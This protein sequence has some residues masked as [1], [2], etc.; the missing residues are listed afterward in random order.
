MV[1]FQEFVE[2]ARKV[3]GNNC[4]YFEDEFVKMSVNTKM[5]CNIHKLYFWQRPDSH[6]N[7]KGT[8]GCPECVKIKA[9]S[10][11]QRKLQKNKETFFKE[12][13]IIH[14]DKYEY[15]E[16]NY[17]D[18]AT[19]MQIW[20]KKCQ[21]FF[22]QSPEC[23]LRGQGCPSCGSTRSNQLRFDLAKKNFFAK[24]FTMHEKDYIF[25]KFEYKG[26]NIDGKL[27]CV[28]CN[29]YIWMSPSSLLSGQNCY[30]CSL[31]RVAKEKRNR[32]GKVFKPKYYQKYPNGYDL[33]QFIYLGSD[34]KGI[35]ICEKHGEFLIT[36]SDLLRGYNCPDCSKSK[37]EIQLKI[38][39]HSLGIKF[40]EQAPLNRTKGYNYR[41]DFYLPD[42]DLYIEYQ[43][44]QHYEPV[45]FFGGWK[46]F[47]S[48]YMKDQYKRDW[49]ERNKHNLLEI[50]YTNFD[51]MKSII[52]RKLKA[53]DKKKEKI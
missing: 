53:I 48:Q 7:G 50:K 1:T 13:P 15:F 10:G 44:I 36:P 38:I 47:F 9:Q 14:Q 43:G 28:S 20:C 31:K 12:A 16:E 2:R 8:I 42:Y 41:F 17:K 6:A 5:W 46:G 37:G 35:A 45:K 32:Y 11:N 22:P 27:W 52:K 39:L 40:I 23:H 26:A 21:K 24:M 29:K 34:V 30:D 51:K 25:D 3:H 49:C 33:S 19:H 18:R 4:E